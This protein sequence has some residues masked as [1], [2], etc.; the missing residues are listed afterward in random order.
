M[1][2]N[3]KWD[4]NEVTLL[5]NLYQKTLLM[6]SCE[7]EQEIEKF[8]NLLRNYAISNGKI[9][10][11]IYRNINGIKMRLAN[12]AFLFTNGKTGLSSFSKLDK[13][14]YGIYKNEP[15]E[16]DRMVEVAKS[17][18][19]YDI[20]KQENSEKNITRNETHISLREEIYIELPKKSES[21]E[22]KYFDWLIQ[23]DKQENSQ[24]TNN[25]F[26]LRLLSKY[27]YIN[28]MINTSLFEI[29]NL[30]VLLNVIQLLSQDSN[31]K[32]DDLEKDSIYSNSLRKYIRFVLNFKNQNKV[33][34]GNQLNNEKVKNIIDNKNIE[35][36]DSNSKF[37]IVEKKEKAK[38]L[39]NNENIELLDSNSEYQIEEKKD[40]INDQ[41]NKYIE[42]LNVN[43][44]KGF[45]LDSE[46]ELSKFRKCFT[47]KFNKTI[48]LN[49]EQLC[50]KIASIGIMYNE[51]I[52]SKR[53]MMNQ[54]T[55]EA[56][57]KFIN[58]SFEEGQHFIYYESIYNKFCDEFYDYNTNNIEM[59]KIYL[60]SFYK[61]VYIFEKKYIM[62]IGGPS[63]ELI[64]EIRK[65]MKDFDMGVTYNEI[66][67]EMD[68]VPIEDIK[69]I[70]TSN[71][72]F[73]RVSNG[74]YI[75]YSCIIMDDKDLSEIETIIKN[76]I[77]KSDYITGTDLFNLT[78]ERLPE[79]HKKNISVI[80]TSDEFR[81]LIKFFLNEK[82]SFKGNI[83][84][85]KRGNK[86]MYDIYSNFCKNNEK[87]T[88]DMLASISKKLNSNIYFDAVYNN[89]LRIDKN[90]F[91]SKD[92]IIFDVAAVDEV[93]E[94]FCTS[95]YILVSE[96]T[97]YLLFPSIE[98]T[99]NCF[100]LEHFVYLYSHK[101]NLLHASSFSKKKCYGVIVKKN[102]EY[103]DFEDVIV[104]VLAKSNAPL[105]QKQALDYL[106][107]NGYLSKKAFSNMEIVIN[108]AIN[109]R[110]RK[111]D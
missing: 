17:S 56:I 70:I 81:D 60:N 36:L 27:C 72:E 101:F 97:N 9:I 88:I 11:P 74:K 24:A 96:I 3:L 33:K 104:D 16:Y 23:I 52:Y 42:I 89:S 86:K 92:A 66:Q 84:S 28:K 54:E 6:S 46:M 107:V 43:F 85:S 67:K 13:K 5:V 71:A 73:I 63:F 49:E 93:I 91:I 90:N 62:K 65:I 7:R 59:L 47:E 50:K 30:D 45:R 100:L 106:T 77:I 68:N 34:E 95:E 58:S 15:S 26:A 111:E 110:N 78:A 22:T 37:K 51:K 39:I 8:S 35:L 21:F 2:S 103:D 87:F 98:Y 94:S 82:F 44:E 1:H 12:I 64:D 53:V 61:N 109:K 57:I 76:E 69:Q 38:D 55:D 18:I 14:L 83:I 79:F 25:V 48:D 20:Y 40:N 80:E 31:Y 19:N 75:H 32:Q 4:I 99:W 102:S 105:N 29:Q 41:L 10:N 108:K